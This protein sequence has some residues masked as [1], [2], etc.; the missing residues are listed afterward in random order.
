MQVL[1]A[2]M[3]AVSVGIHVRREGNK[4]RLSPDETE[5][6][7]TKNEQQARIRKKSS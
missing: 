2:I 7:K 3:L 4:A 1:A 5:E 6:A